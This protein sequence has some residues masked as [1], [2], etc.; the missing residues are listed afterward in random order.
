MAEPAEVQRRGINGAAVGRVVLGALAAE[1][2][3]APEVVLAQM[4]K[5]GL[6]QV[7]MLAEVVVRGQ[8]RLGGNRARHGQ[9]GDRVGKRNALP[10]VPEKMPENATISPVISADGLTIA[11]LVG[12]KQGTGHVLG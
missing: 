1:V 3:L 9:P 6:V 11:A 2:V 7:G 12:L 4:G 10:V 8:A 5:N